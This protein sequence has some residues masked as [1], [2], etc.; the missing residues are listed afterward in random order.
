[1]SS[2]T[3]RYRAATL[4][5]LTALLVGTA[6]STS[7][8]PAPRLDSA[9][10]D[11]DLAASANPSAADPVVADDAFSADVA[12]RRRVVK[13]D[14]T[15]TGSA[16]CDGCDAESTALQVLYVSRTQEARLDNTAVAWTQ[17]CKDCI[18]T[19]LSVQVVAMTG[20]PSM[21]PNNRALALNADCVSC[22]VA[23]AAY[24]V[25]VSSPPGDR[26]S[27]NTVAALRAWVAKQ[28]EQLRLSAGTP[29][30]SG[31]GRRVQKGADAALSDLEAL[32]TSD[33]GGTTVSSDVQLSPAG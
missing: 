24:Q 2:T 19:A 33:L 25:V 13:S 23:G 22:Q 31:A 18:A 30:L 20:V 11:L 16:T 8:A 15:A 9:L 4:G 21:V 1:M 32:V 14:V 5:V 10:R 6:A 3:T 17:S 7:G 29:Q 12:S 28:A 27:R 26:L